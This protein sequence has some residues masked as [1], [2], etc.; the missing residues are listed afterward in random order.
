MR[1]QPIINGALLIAHRA[2]WVF[3]SSRVNPPLPTSS[4][5]GSFQPPGPDLEARF[6]F[7]LKLNSID[8]HMSLMSDVVRKELPIDLPH[9]G[10]S[11]RPPL[12]REKNIYR[13]VALRASLIL[14]NLINA[15]T[16]S[17]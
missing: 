15:G 4:I 11:S 13:P 14:G 8:P 3:S 9:S 7:S 2:K 17:L 16:L 6:T 1:S 5:S 12:Q 10:T